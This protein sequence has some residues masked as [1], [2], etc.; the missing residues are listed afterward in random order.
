MS[1]ENV[2]MVRKLYESEGPEV[3]GRHRPTS[4][5]G[6]RPRIRVAV[7]RERRS[8]FLSGS[9]ERRLTPLG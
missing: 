3:G 9:D 8:S 5:W 1:Q 7:A 2:E 6:L 4:S